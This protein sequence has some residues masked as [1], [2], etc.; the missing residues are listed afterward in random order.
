MGDAPKTFVDLALGAQLPDCFDT[1]KVKLCR[2]VGGHCYYMAVLNFV[3][4]AEPT[5]RKHG[6]NSATWEAMFNF[7]RQMSA[8]STANK[9]RHAR[10][11]RRLPDPVQHIHQAYQL[12]WNQERKLADLPPVEVTKGMRNGGDSWA[13]LET[14][15]YE[16]PLAVLHTTRVED[17]RPWCRK[18][19]ENGG[20]WMVAMRLAEPIAV[21]DVDRVT[22]AFVERVETA[23]AAAAASNRVLLGGVAYTD[24]AAGKHAIAW[25]MCTD[26]DEPDHVSVLLFDSNHSRADHSY[27]KSPKMMFQ[28]HVLD[29][30]LLTD[31]TAVII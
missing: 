28:S 31:V 2:Q 27:A 17:V 19:A 7:A 18:A 15:F 21:N 30:A 6:Y 13:L 26:D 8:C 25:N 16:T 20:P 3:E 10:L 5:L 11:C 12:L 29:K 4:R 23:R 14:L 1:G 24:T 22:D 9:Q